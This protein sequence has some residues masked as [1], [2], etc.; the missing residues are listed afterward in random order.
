MIIFNEVSKRI[1]DTAG[2]IIKVLVLVGVTQSAAAIAVIDVL[3]VEITDLA[4]RVVGAGDAAHQ[5]RVAGVVVDKVALGVA[6]VAGGVLEVLV[7]A[8]IALSAAPAVVVHVLVRG[9]ADFA[10]CVVGAGDAAGQTRV[11]GVVEEEV[12][13]QV[14]DIAGVVLEVLVLTGITL[15]ATVI[16]IGDILDAEVTSYTFCGV[17]ALLTAS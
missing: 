9:V 7:L 15:P 4:D 13:G 16:A 5:T 8:G 1:T 6:V 17:S 3:V 10:D 2:P 12:A 14:A 11:A